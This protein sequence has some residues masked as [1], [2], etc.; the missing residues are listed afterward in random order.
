M[1]DSGD[2][3]DGGGGVYILR[4]SWVGGWWKCY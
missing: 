4:G 1:L 3:V 2:G